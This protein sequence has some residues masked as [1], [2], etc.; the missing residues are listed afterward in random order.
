[1]TMILSILVD[2]GKNEAAKNAM[3]TVLPVSAGFIG[4]IMAFYFS[5]EAGE[6]KAGDAEALL[7]Q[8]TII[9]MRDGCADLEV[10]FDPNTLDGSRTMK[11]VL[12]EAIGK[13]DDPSSATFLDTEGELK[14]LQFSYMEKLRQ[15][16]YWSKD[17]YALSLQ[18]LASNTS[19]SVIV[20][21][22]HSSI[23]MLA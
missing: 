20:Q 12:D 3:N 7:D 5:D 14:D 2:D 9:F 4:S 11:S 23:D 22:S 18:E 15:K 17:F 10:T 16:K 19:G 13:S 8:R 6:D 1:M 21:V